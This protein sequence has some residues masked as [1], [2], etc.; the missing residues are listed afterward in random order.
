[1]VRWLWIL[2]LVLAL[3]AASACAEQGTGASSAAFAPAS[4]SQAE[5]EATIRLKADVTLDPLAPETRAYIEK[6][7]AQLPVDYSLG[8][9]YRSMTAKLSGAYLYWDWDG[10][11]VSDTTVIIGLQADLADGVVYPAEVTTVQPVNLLPGA[12]YYWQVI[13]ETDRGT[14]RSAIGTFHTAPGL[15]PLAIDGVGN[16]RD[17][18]GWQTED[19]LTIQYGRV[20]RTAKLTDITPEGVVT[21]VETLG[22]VSEID[23]RGKTGLE[24]CLTDGVGPLGRGVHYYNFAATQYKSALTAR[25]TADS[26][27]PFCDPANYP[28][29]FHCA[30]GADRAGTLASMLEGICGC[31]PAVLVTDYELTGG[32]WRTYNSYDDMMA[33]L[34]AYAGDTFREK[35]WTALGKLGM[36]PM[37]LSNIRNLMTGDSAIFAADS[38][39][40][41]AETDGGRAFTLDLRRSGGV[42]AVT[43]AGVSVPFTFEGNVLTVGATAGEG[44]ITLKDGGTLFFL[45]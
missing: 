6:N 41:A 23:L 43:V 34:D 39:Q 14:V 5:P 7:L 12:T 30:G 29:L 17:L 42:A 15:R 11:R 44:S 16:A 20:Y 13:A 45:L 3:A 35:V 28:I 19:G 18:G 27:R 21:A 22:V 8:E 25:V 32:R 31:S 9:A 26:L 2:L 37:E 1:M 24:E 40:K 10:M 33:T 38:L 36:T 4:S